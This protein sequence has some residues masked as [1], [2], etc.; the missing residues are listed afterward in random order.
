MGNKEKKKAPLIV[1]ILLTLILAAILFFV[2]LSLFSPKTKIE[3][4]YNDG[5]LIYGI[6]TGSGHEIKAGTYTAHVDNA[7]TFKGET[8]AHAP[9]LYD[10]WIIDHSIDS[11]GELTGI[12]PD[13]TVGGMGNDYIDITL[14]KGDYIVIRPYE[15]GYYPSGQFVM[16]LKK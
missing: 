16:K 7:M 2:Y 13:Y 6:E 12:E 8:M 10:I 14:N 9:G 1:K 15:V 4:D 5:P 3:C 11:T